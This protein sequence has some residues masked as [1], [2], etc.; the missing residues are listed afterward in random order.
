MGEKSINRIL[1]RKPEGKR[2]VVRRRCR[3]KGNKKTSLREIGRDCMDG[4]DVA[5][6]KGPTESSS[7]HDN[8]PSGSI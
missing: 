7:E 6:D 1:V 5:Q 3:W 8:K 2:S 4:N